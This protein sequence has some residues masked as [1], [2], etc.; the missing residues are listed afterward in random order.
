MEKKEDD[1]SYGEAFRDFRTQGNVYEVYDKLYDEIDVHYLKDVEDVIVVG[2]GP[3]LSELTFLKKLVKNV[4]RLTVI[5]KDPKFV[6]MMKKNV[7]RLLPYNLEFNC[8][9]TMAQ[10]WQGPSGDKPKTDLILIFHSL[11]YFDEAERK[12][13][14]D[15]CFNNW[16]NHNGK[17]FIKLHK[18]MN[19]TNIPYYVN[20][21]FRE[22]KRKLYIEAYTVKRELAE[23]GYSIDKV[24][25]YQYYHDLKTCKQSMARI[26][27][28]HAVPAYEDDSIIL[29]T[30]EKYYEADGKICTSG[31]L[32]SVLGKAGTYIKDLQLKKENTDFLFMVAFDTEVLFQSEI[33]LS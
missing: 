11:Y 26:I 30:L 33:C 23:L 28:Q 17:L 3:A 22:T 18:D 27:R 9:L 21:V 16:L 4:K 24:Y 14:Y 6:E 10:S 7:E 31:E 29:Q 13:L 2:G 5:E 32:F 15:K 20:N 8:H 1:Y 19:E 12:A 25:P